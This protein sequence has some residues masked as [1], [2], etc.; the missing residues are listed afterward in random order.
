MVGSTLATADRLAATSQFVLYALGMGSVLT[1]LTLSAA[2]AES[3][4]LVRARRLGR[5]LPSAS[6]LV[7]LL[8][9]AYL[10]YS[11]LTLGGL[12]TSGHAA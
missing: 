2:V 1:L 5:V 8:A 7:L 6:A 4:L 12:L 11:W 9:G 10:I 3:T